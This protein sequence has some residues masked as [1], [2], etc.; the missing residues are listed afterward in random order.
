MAL[1]SLV[2]C[3]SW[4]AGPDDAVAVADGAGVGVDVACEVDVDSAI[5]PSVAGRTVP[6]AVTTARIPI[7]A[8]RPRRVILTNVFPSCRSRSTLPLHYGGNRHR[9]AAPRT[10]DVQNGIFLIIRRR[11]QTR[12][13]FAGRI[14]QRRTR[15]TSTNR[16]ALGMARVL[17]SDHQRTN[18]GEGATRP[19]LDRTSGHHARHL[20][21]AEADASR[22]PRRESQRLDPTAG[23]PRD[24]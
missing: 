22:N 13:T 8:Q 14:D 7:R 5:A 11:G 3:E 20:S 19:L 2:P 18:D 9:P 1:G 16:C 17:S 15:G 24:A 23:G 21:A 6:K 10:L 12:C 4:L